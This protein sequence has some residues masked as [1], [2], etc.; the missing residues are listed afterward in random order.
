VPKVPQA[1]K[2]VPIPLILG[3]LGFYQGGNLANWFIGIEGGL[4]I[5]VGGLFLSIRF[6]KN[7]PDGL[8]YFQEALLG[9]S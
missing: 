3:G 6:L 8:F 1:P 9:L 5:K 2:E 7:F 4:R